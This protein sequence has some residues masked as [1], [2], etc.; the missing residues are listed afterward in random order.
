MRGRAHGPREYTCPRHIVRPCFQFQG[1][2]SRFPPPRSFFPPWAGPVKN[3]LTDA[4]HRDGT[5]VTASDLRFGERFPLLPPSHP[6]PN[7]STAVAKGDGSSRDDN[8]G[9][10]NGGDALRAE[11]PLERLELRSLVRGLSR[12]LGL[13]DA[14]G[15]AK[16][17]VF[18]VAVNLDKSGGPVT[19]W[20]G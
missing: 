2:H 20:I 4:G 19:V 18:N 14:V 8:G 17:F 5:T 15:K 12:A 16:V 6:R 10:R 11:G 3:I 9:L 13:V 7:R 1:I